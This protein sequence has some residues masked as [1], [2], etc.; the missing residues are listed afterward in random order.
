M[1]DINVNNEYTKMNNLTPF[2]LCVLQ[3][4]PF[5]EADFDAVT[6]YQ[7]LC[8]VVEYLNNVIDN[9]NKQNTNITQLEQ[10][11]ITLYNYVKD[12]FDNLDVQEEINKKLDE[13]AADGSLSKL[14]QP[15]FDEYKK[16]IDSEV[17]TQN[18]KIVVLENRMNTFTSLPS[19]STSGDAELIDIRVPAS[20]FNDDKTYSTAGEAVRGQVSTL[21]KELINTTDDKWTWSDDFLNANQNFDLSDIVGNNYPFKS[22]YVDSVELSVH[23]VSGNSAVLFI[24]DTNR[25]VL[26]KTTKIITNNDLIIPVNALINSDF[27]VFVSYSG[28]KYYN[29]TN[30]YA[31]KWAG[32]SFANYGKYLVGD[33]LP[34]FN[35]KGKIGFSFKVKFATAKREIIENT[36]NINMYH[37]VN[38]KIVSESNNAH[39]SI[40]KTGEVYSRKKGTISGCFPCFFN[41]KESITFKMTND[42]A[43]IIVSIDDSGKFVSLGFKGDGIIFASFN[44][45]GSLIA[46]D[47]TQSYLVQTWL[48]SNITLV[49]NDEYFC[50][51]YRNGHFIYKFDIRHTS[52]D[53]I[54]HNF[55][56]GVYSS[57]QD[58]IRVIV[59]NSIVKN[60][61]FLDDLCVLGDSFTDNT[62][63]SL[64][65]GTFYFTRWYEYAREINNI[66]TVYNYGFGGTCMSPVVSGKDSFYDRMK[67]M[68]KEH[69]NVS[70]VFVLGGTNDYNYNV[71]LGTINDDTTDTF[72]GTLNKMCEYLKNEYYHTPTIFCTPIMR[73]SPSDGKTET[74]PANEQTN[75]NGNTLEEYVN[76]MIET[77]RKWSIPC[78]DA[79]HKT[80]IC[81]QSR[82]TKNYAWF[83]N[84]GIH[85]KQNGHRR[86]GTRFGEYAK[87][88]L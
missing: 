36:N 29:S 84:D 42:E 66:K 19:G 77:C 70:A 45:D 13:M 48:H 61:I 22:G 88:F 78:F 17:N 7:L 37:T 80:E 4:F 79:Y 59:I 87:E 12:Y 9:N 6:N 86:L 25:K 81:P 68:Y 26:F 71:Q 58:G 44:A 21:H 31:D 16:T 3:N 14:I 47:Y 10:N 53:I 23:A 1:S 8:K 15:L 46:V 65:A 27:F 30:V 62:R 57:M 82:N 51:I 11:F 74:I 40:S 32:L 67:T 39:F 38:V 5:I 24:T 55:G 85:M 43:W 76:A 56:V 35:N 75:S 28:L 60:K 54:N 41:L 72:Y 52:T 73:V 49:W 69:P 34:N 50:S 83:M 18:D 63:D 33:V 64:G 20:G 2:K